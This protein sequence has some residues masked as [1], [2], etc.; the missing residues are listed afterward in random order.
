LLARVDEAVSAERL[1]LWYYWR[2]NIES[3]F[4][5]M[6]QAGHQLEEWEQEKGLAIFKRLLIAAAACINVWDLMRTKTPE[7]E[8]ACEF[9]VRL[10][11]R[12]MK[13]DV[14]VTAS[15]LLDGIFKLLTLIE[16]LQNY[17]IDELKAFAQTALRQLQAT[18]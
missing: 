12:Q 2:W 10:S 3:F 7:A 5:L 8:E 11:G 1:A 17:S 13:R 15:A 6:K 16:T 9:L 18:G 14:P 4:K